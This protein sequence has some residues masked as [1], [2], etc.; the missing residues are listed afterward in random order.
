MMVASDNNDI[1]KNLPSASARPQHQ[2]NPHRSSSTQQNPHHHQRLEGVLN[3]ENDPDTHTHPFI[4]NAAIFL[5]VLFIILTFP[6]TIFFCF[7]IVQEYERAVIFR[8]GRL[9]DGG[10]RGPGIFFI[11][12][13]LD[14]FRR[15]DLRTITFDV[16]PQEILTK[17]SGMIC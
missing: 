15:V 5:S 9:R 6:L 7:A 16:P 11:M 2:P 13:C 12:P 4:E 3:A 8:M 17:D 10:A 14:T 1:E